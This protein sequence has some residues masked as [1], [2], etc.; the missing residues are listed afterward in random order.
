MSRIS[1]TLWATCK[2]TISYIVIFI[3]LL[4][5]AFFFSLMC[6]LIL[7]G[8]LFWFA[9]ILIVGVFIG[10]IVDKLID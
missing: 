6:C 4:A 7:S 8:H 9:T 3:A 2:D 5:T 10:A 1:K